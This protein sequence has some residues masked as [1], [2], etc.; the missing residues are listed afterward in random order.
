MREKFNFCYFTATNRHEDVSIIQTMVNSARKVG[1]AEDFHVFAPTPIAECVFHPTPPNYGWRDH[2]AKLDFARKLVDS[3]YDFVVWLDSDNYFVRDPDDLSPFIRQNPLWVMMESD[4]TI[5]PKT[6][7][8]GWYHRK[9][10]EIDALYRQEGLTHSKSWN[11]NGGMWMI[12][13]E[14]INEIADRVESIYG[15]WRQGPWPE[16]NDE[17]ILACLGASLVDDPELNDFERCKNFWACDWVGIWNSRLPDGNDWE[18]TDWMHGTKQR[19]NPAIVHVMRG[20]HLMQN[21]ASNS[22]EPV[23]T[24]LHELLAECGVESDPNCSCKAFAGMMDQWGVQGCQQHRKEIL[25]HLVEASDGKWLSMMKVAARGF[26]SCG[27]LL[28]EAI[29]RAQNNA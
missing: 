18:Y 29:K 6:K 2:L 22:G 26:F 10:E 9:H 8:D 21:A 16:V 28:D 27:Q 3:H 25:T 7:E 4:M 14:N 11:S 24:K 1:V 23:G 15:K 13:R 5:T 20:K 19:I 17:G 12:R